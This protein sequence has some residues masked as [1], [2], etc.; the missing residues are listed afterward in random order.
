M[1]G[2]DL[3]S[4]HIQYH[5]N[6]FLDTVDR[7]VECRIDRERFAVVRGGHDDAGPPAPDQR[8]P[9]PGRRV[10][11]R[12]PGS[13]GPRRCAD[14]TGSATGRCSSASI[15]SITRRAS[16][17]GCAAVDRLL[18]TAPGA[19]GAVPL[20]PGRGPEPDAPAGVPRPERRGR[21]R[22][23]TGSTG[24]TARPGWQPVVFLNEH[25]GPEDDLP[26]LPDGRRVRGQLAARR[27]EPGGQGVRDRPD[28]RAGRA[29]A[30]EVH[31]GGP[32]ADRRGAGQP[33]RRGRA[34]RRACTR[35]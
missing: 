16:R 10:P 12:R 18:D 15:G 34:G 11:R 27:D 28:R 4:F 31:R 32:R 20:R 30:V 23:P 19:E 14:G 22:S 25:H 5:C 17:S 33:V 26:A 9:G 1:L 8:R 13:G 21:R 3:L 2:N 24:G 35:R 7:T 29:G 6:N